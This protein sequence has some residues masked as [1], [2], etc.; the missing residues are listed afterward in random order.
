MG[1]ALPI[2]PGPVLALPI[3]LDVVAEPP[4]LALFGPLLVDVAPEAAAESLPLEGAVDEL[5]AEVALV[6]SAVVPDCPVLVGPVDR[7][8]SSALFELQPHTA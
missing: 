7:S 3:V 6:R 1:P 5:A 2:G 8:E 4:V